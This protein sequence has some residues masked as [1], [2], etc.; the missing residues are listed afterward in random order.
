MN[1]AARRLVWGRAGQRCEYCRLHQNDEPYFRFHIEHI[2]AH[3]HR[4]SDDLTNLALACHHCNQRKGTNLSGIDAQTGKVVR[5][6]HPRLQQWVR[7]FRM[8]GFRIVGRTQCGRVTVALL[9]MNARDRIELRKAGTDVDSAD[10]QL[11]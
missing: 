8:A 7:H 6:F 10:D 5:L 4:G 2:V 11:D 1:A 3:Q 9:D